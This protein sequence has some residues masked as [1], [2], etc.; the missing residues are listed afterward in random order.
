MDRINFPTSQCWIR[1]RFMKSHLSYLFLAFGINETRIIILRNRSKVNEAECFLFMLNRISSLQTL[2]ELEEFWGRYNCDLSRMFSYMVN[3]IYN[4]FKHLIQDNMRFWLPHFPIFIEC[5]QNRIVPP[6]PL[7]CLQIGSTWDATIIPVANPGG[8]MIQQV[9]YNGKDRVHAL[10]FGSWGLPNGMF[11]DMQDCEVGSRHD[12][13]L[14]TTSGINNRLRE[15]QENA[16]VDL[17]THL[18]TYADKG[19]DLYF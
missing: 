6:V 9:L 4:R 13:V 8:G 11:G 3:R 16:N 15:V 19:I 7:G 17:G 14:V 10:K 12:E 2:E 5:M 1:L 18:I